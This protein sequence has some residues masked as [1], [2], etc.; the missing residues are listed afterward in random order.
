M[1]QEPF[2]VDFIREIREKDHGIGGVKLWHMYKRKF[3]GNSP[4]GRDRFEDVVDKYGLKVRNKVRKPKTTDSTHGLP[5]YPNLIKVFIPDAP[6][7]LWVSDITYI[8]ILGNNDQYRF[9]YL[10]II[11]DAFSEEIKGY[12]VGKSLE[13]QYS[14]DALEMALSSLEG[15]KRDDIHLI[16]HSD[17]GVQY[18]SAKYITLLKDYNIRISMTENGDPK[19]NPQAERINSTIKNEILMGCEF[20]SLKEAVVAVAKAVDFYNTERPHM[21]IGM[22]TPAEASQC[23]GVR[24]M[25]WTSYRELAIKRSLEKKIAENGLPLAPVRGLLP[26][27]ALQSTPDRDKT[28]IVNLKQ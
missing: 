10:T 25:K 18:A 12:C 5:T 26:G 14:I 4:L 11:M 8:E 21:S 3:A 19:E 28:W 2:A 6:N 16:H 22:M 24:D 17:R 15:K 9:C 27:Y 23:C 20:H 7:Q 1:T 13:T